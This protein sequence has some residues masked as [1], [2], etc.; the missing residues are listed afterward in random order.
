MSPQ[1][2]GDLRVPHL[3]RP[4]QRRSPSL[5]VR[6]TDLLTDP[7][8]RLFPWTSSNRI[9]AIGR[10]GQEHGRDSRLDR[11]EQAPALVRPFRRNRSQLCFA[12]RVVGA[13][14]RDRGRPTAPALRIRSAAIG[15][16]DGSDHGRQQAFR[17]RAGETGYALHRS[18]TLGGRQESA[19]FSY[20]TA[21]GRRGC[22]Q[23]PRVSTEEGPK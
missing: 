2:S 15:P 12:P 20:R 7:P 22:P 14:H 10:S 21:K 4:S 13:R 5:R 23:R 17:T 18:R 3:L 1:S 9:L 19:I 16:R 11:I 6:L 8:K